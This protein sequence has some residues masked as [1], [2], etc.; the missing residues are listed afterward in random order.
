VRGDGEEGGRRQG[1]ARER[2]GGWLGGVVSLC[3]VPRAALWGGAA[4]PSARQRRGVQRVKMERR[5]AGGGAERGSEGE[6]GAVVSRTL[7]ER[8]G[9]LGL[10]R[11]GGEGAGC[12]AWIAPGRAANRGCNE[13]LIGRRKMISGGLLARRSHGGTPRKKTPLLLSLFSSRDMCAL[14]T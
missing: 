8:Q 4:G 5:V 11:R 6:D 14:G 9:W 3:G 7:E 2:G 1:G 10:G 12:E 13:G